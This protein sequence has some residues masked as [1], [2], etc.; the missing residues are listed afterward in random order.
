MEEIFHLFGK[1]LIAE[2]L[3][4]LLEPLVVAK[5]SKELS[6]NS[7]LFFFF[8]NHLLLRFTSLVFLLVPLVDLND[9][10]EVEAQPQ[11]KLIPQSR[12][13]PWLFVGL[14]LEKLNN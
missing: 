1:G 11:E 12:Y 7:L 13:L 14:V 4:I 3:L 8:I 10:I 5:T 2:G 9:L 6:D